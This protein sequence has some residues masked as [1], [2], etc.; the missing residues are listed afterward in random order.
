MTKVSLFKGNP[1]ITLNPD[2]KWPFSFG[3]QKARLV[4]ANIEAIKKFVADFESKKQFPGEQNDSVEQNNG[5]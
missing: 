3:L 5:S 1:T 4:L 2:D